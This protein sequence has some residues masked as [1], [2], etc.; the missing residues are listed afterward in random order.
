V[1]REQIEDQN[2]LI[3]RLENGLKLA[4]DQIDDLSNQQT[5]GNV[6]TTKLSTPDIYEEEDDINYEEL[7]E[8]TLMQLLAQTRQALMEKRTSVSLNLDSLDFDSN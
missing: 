6:G 2:K 7:D 1:L 8:A 4:M 3:V 5:G